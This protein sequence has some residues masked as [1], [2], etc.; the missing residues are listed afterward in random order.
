M[1]DEKT[2]SR[3]PFL[4][5]V[6]GGGA[7]NGDPGADV[8]REAAPEAFSAERPPTP[9]ELIETMAHGLMSQLQA[10]L[11]FAPKFPRERL[12]SVAMFIAKEQYMINTEILPRMA[13]PDEPK[14]RIA[15]KFTT[16][17]ANESEAHIPRDGVKVEGFRRL[18]G[19]HEPGD[20]ST[21]ALIYAFFDSPV[22]RAIL[23]MNGFAYQ[24]SFVGIEPPRIVTR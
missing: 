2:D 12:P 24:F 10:A 17:P 11:F 21:M 16:M 22:A 18:E 20:A 14:P 6:D 7:E 5:V 13:N 9:E 19:I 1:S 15:L 8:E 3:P 4:H 23:K